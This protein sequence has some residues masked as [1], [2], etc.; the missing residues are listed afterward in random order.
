VRSV[1]K[2]PAF[3]AAA[4]L[5][6]ALGIGATTTIFS[7]IQGVLLDPYPMYRDIGR[8]IQLSIHDQASARP[9]GRGYLQLD[10]FLEYQ[11]Q[12]TLLDEVIA[13][14]GEDVMWTTPR[15]PNRS[16]A[17]D[18]RQHVH[19]LGV[20]RDRR[21]HAGAGRRQ[22]RG[23]AGVRHELQALGVALRP[24]PVDRR[25]DLHVQRRPDDA[26]RGDARAGL[27]ARGGRVDA[28]APRSRRRRLR[29][30][31]FRFQARLK[32]GV[33]LEQA[34]AQLDA[35]GHR[36]APTRPRDY[37]ERFVVYAESF[38]D[39]IIGPFRTTLYT[40][41]AAVALLLLIAC[42]NV[43]NM[44]LSRAAGREQEMAVRAALGASRT[45]L[46]RQLLVESLLLAVAGAA[47][48]CLLRGSASRRLS[49]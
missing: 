48:G 22:A 47:I 2:Q 5:A 4:V 29:D 7:V 30:R 44:L 26:R 21:P 38:V 10:E 28:A 35:I 39:S 33:T 8:L 3:T 49:P 14:T 27:E 24:R 18:H 15:G 23:A 12:A 9:G 46:V 42:T 13:G 45:R 41:A 20:G 40:M 43:A 19:V 37:P 17:A 32:D 16:T 31:Y 25:P 34:S 36:F 1:R 11:R 6:L